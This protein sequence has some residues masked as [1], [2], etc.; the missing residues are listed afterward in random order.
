MK[1]RIE[2]PIN[3]QVSNKMQTVRFISFQERNKGVKSKV[4]QWQIHMWKFKVKSNCTLTNKDCDECKLELKRNM[5]ELFVNQTHNTHHEPN[6]EILWLT[7][8]VASN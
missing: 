6:L 7:M 2:N 5:N 3:S 8:G 1:L 4:G